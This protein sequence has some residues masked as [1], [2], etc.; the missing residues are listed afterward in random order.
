MAAD[1][2][3]AGSGPASV[4]GAIRR[5]FALSLE[6]AVPFVASNMAWAVVA[7]AYLL[8]LVGFPILAFA[9]PLLAIPTS[10]LMR[11]AVVA[12]RSGVPTLP[13]AWAEMGRLPERKVGMA[14]VQLLV[15][16]VAIANLDLS[17][18]IGGALGLLSAGV[19]L[20]AAVATAILSI[21]VWPIVCDP[22]REAPLRVQL[23]VAVSVAVQRP[24]QLLVLALLAALAVYV[25]TQLLVPALVLPTVV[26]LA[27][28][29]YVVPAAD[30]IRP[31]PGA[32]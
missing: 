1:E 9:A 5:S 14:F 21:A 26:L 15:I 29:G 18:R 22:A 30:A 17:V 13:V 23:R 32:A 20:Y 27:I 19:A 25:S 7:G 31:T 8:L 12:I 6:W 24:L 11:L 10:A 28:A 2:S 3:H 4:A 16:G